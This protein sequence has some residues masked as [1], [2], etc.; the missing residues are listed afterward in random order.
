MK[1]L[2]VIILGVLMS[3]TV[4]AGQQC[5]QKIKDKFEP[6][7]FQMTI[8]DAAEVKIPSY[9]V[10]LGV[11]ETDA[12]DFDKENGYDRYLVTFSNVF[13]YISE[14]ELVANKTAKNPK[15]SGVVRTE[16]A[17]MVRPTKDGDCDIRRIKY[18][19]F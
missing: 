3:S 6:I 8:E 2:L 14:K 19:L 1:S 15:V 11:K 17:V 16:Y 9:L 7:A 4:F 12:T 10:G 13:A 18:N 5:E